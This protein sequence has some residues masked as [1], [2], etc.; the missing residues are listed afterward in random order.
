M[1][2]DRAVVHVNLIIIGG[3]HQRVPA[4][5]YAGAMGQCLQ[6]EEFGHGQGDV[7]AV[8]GATV[9]LGIHAQ[10]TALEHFLVAIARR[11]WIAAIVVAWQWRGAGSP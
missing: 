7:L 9:A 1:A 5:H 11:F 10:R 2:V 3:V 8:P 6:D 4:F